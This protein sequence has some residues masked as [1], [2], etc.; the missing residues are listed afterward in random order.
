MLWDGDPR[1]LYAAVNS[2]D[3]IVDAML[4]TG[5]A[6]D[7]RPP[8]DEWIHCANKSNAFR[9]AIDIPSGICAETGRAGNPAFRADA[10]LTFV[11]RKPAM[12]L[13]ASRVHFGEIEVLGI[14]VPEGLLQ[15]T[16]TALERS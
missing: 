14:G 15:R 5:A 13:A 11:A 2:A 4:G 10:T 7:P 9:L 1:G 3:V 12:E 8:F 16:L 6:G